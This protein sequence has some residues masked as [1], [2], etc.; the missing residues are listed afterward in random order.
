MILSS[1]QTTTL[2]KGGD[3]SLYLPLG[4]AGLDGDLCGR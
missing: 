2:F 1:G 3:E 4:V